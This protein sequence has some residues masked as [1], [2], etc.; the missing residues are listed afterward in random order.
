MKTVDYNSL[1]EAIGDFDD[2]GKAKE[3]QLALWDCVLLLMLKTSMTEE[4]ILKLPTWRFEHYLNRL[5][6]AQ[7]HERP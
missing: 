4:A 3:R 5:L 6:E 7:E 1:S 2:E